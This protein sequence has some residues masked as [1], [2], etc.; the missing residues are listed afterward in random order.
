MKHIVLSI[1]FLFL[2][3][4][5]SC[6]DTKKEQL[7]AEKLTEKMEALENEVDQTA[8]QVQQKAEEAEDALKALDSI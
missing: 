3:G 1:C 2:L 5:T 6:R 7:E 4:I 8:D